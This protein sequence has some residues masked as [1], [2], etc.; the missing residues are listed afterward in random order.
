MVRFECS[1][2]WEVDEEIGVGVV[3]T[4]RELIVSKAIREAVVTDSK[5]IIISAEAD[6][7]EDCEGLVVVD[8]STVVVIVDFAVVFVESNFSF[9]LWSVEIV[10]NIV[11][12]FSCN[13]DS[14]DGCVP[15]TSVTIS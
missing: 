6:S 5:L 1:V 2:T 14:V 10:V 3:V 11:D 15:L 4:G 9:V 7:E 12:S 13:V 8:S